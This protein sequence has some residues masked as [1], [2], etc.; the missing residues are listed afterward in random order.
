MATL[1]NVLQPHPENTLHLRLHRA[2]S[3]VLTAQEFVSSATSHP[4][5]TSSECQANS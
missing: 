4:V 5:T 2:R 3:V 1:L